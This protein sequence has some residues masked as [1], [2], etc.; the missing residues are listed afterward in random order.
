MAK[1]RAHLIIS[2]IVQGV[3]FRSTSRSQALRLY[4]TGWIKNRADGRVETVIEGEDKAV[5]NFIQWCHEGPPGA[6]VDNVDIMWEKYI[7]EFA[8]FSI[9]Y[10]DAW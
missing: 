2:G 10:S 7:G 6:K 5:A 1:T 8:A 3:F 4:L 9:K